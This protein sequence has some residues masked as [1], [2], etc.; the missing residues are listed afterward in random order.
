MA[1]LLVTAGCPEVLGVTPLKKARRTRGLPGHTENRR[2]SKESG[3][4][5]DFRLWDDDPRALFEIEEARRDTRQSM[6]FFDRAVLLREVGITGG[7]GITRNQDAGVNIN[8]RESFSIA[9]CSSFG[10]AAIGS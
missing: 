5:E 1:G 8:K 4:P 9:A 10:R 7:A 2:G 6:P 3:L